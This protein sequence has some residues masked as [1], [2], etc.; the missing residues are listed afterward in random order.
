MI[1]SEKL[2][3]KEI[4]KEIEKKNK[5]NLELKMDNEKIIKIKADLLRDFEILEAEYNLSTKR[6][7]RKEEDFKLKVKSL[8][9]EKNRLDERFN[10][11]LKIGTK[12][13]KEVQYDLLIQFF[14]RLQN[15][16][17]GKQSSLPFVLAEYLDANTLNDRLTMVENR[18]AVLL[19]EN[20][21]NLNKNSSLNNSLCDS[22]NKKLKELSTENEILGYHLYK[23]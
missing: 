9:N 18:A 14:N 23:I 6:F 13:N 7:H 17:F 4:F 21:S 19:L 8:E 12:S 2:K 3:M 10:T 5:E 16:F 22:I 20:G 1:E 15:L 11:M